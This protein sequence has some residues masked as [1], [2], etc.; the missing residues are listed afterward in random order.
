M[1]TATQQQRTARGA[2]ALGV[3]AMIATSGGRFGVT[4][5]TM[6]IGVVVAGEQ[7][8]LARG[9]GIRPVAAVGLVTILALH[10]A[11]ATEGARAP[12]WLPPIAAGG[13]ALSYIAMLRRHVRTNV[14]RALI[15]TAVPILIAGMLGAFIPAIHGLG[16]SRAAW[17]FLL[18]IFGASAGIA[19]ARR[20]NAAR[21]AVFG[22]SVLGALLVAS[23]L[24]IT[25]SSEYEAGRAIV[26]ALV[27]AVCAPLGE[28]LASRVEA[29]LGGGDAG[30]RALALERVGGALL[31]APAFFFA[32]RALTT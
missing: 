30:R 27:V 28:V 15:A 14:T 11:G 13:L 29:D 5:L 6:V 4:V 18:L 17:G 25:W 3:L 32:F 23:G 20:T 22:T 31:A 9:V 26:L 19:V 1:V 21:I 12:R 7:F 8:R 16:G 24:A 10:L 2:I